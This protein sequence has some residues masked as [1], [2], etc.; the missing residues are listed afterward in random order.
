MQFFDDYFSFICAAACVVGYVFE[1]A[2]L[3]PAEPRVRARLHS[4]LLI[5]YGFFVLFCL[6]LGALELVGRL[7]TLPLPIPRDASNPFA[8]AA[9]G[10]F[11]LGLLCIAAFVFLLG[12]D[13]R[14]AELARHSWWPPWRAVR[15]LETPGSWRLLVVFVV[16]GFVLNAIITLLCRKGP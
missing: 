15:P 7:E 5:A 14:M 2:T 4:T 9:C 3:K 12:G 1:R 16:A 6:A 8:L 11:W 10:L 13:K